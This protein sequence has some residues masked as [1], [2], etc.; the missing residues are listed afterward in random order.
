M[1]KHEKILTVLNTMYDDNLN[2][3]YASPNLVAECARL[4]DIKLTP[5]DVVFISDVYGTDRCPSGRSYLSE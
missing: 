2:P 4:L 3:E 5:D 1:T